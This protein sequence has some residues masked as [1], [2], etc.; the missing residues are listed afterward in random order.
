MTSRG[1][2]SPGNY[3][4][5]SSVLLHFFW[6]TGG[7]GD[8]RAAREFILE[9]EK[10]NAVGILSNWSIMEII[11]VVRQ[12]M[13]NNDVDNY[14]VIEQEVVNLLD[15][16]FEI[17]GIRIIVG[18]P[19]ELSEFQKE[20]P[21]LWNILEDALEHLEETNYGIDW[22]ETETKFKLRGIASAD[23][24]HVFIATS[25]GCDYLAT[26]DKGF[27]ADERPITIYDVREKKERKS[28]GDA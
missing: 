19:F 11:S 1:D 2:L 14:S 8:T 7:G 28:N 16:L 23:A 4:L 22:L 20:A 5:D 13:I 18:T 9:I 10:G 24:L 15:K 17:K 3:Y 12:S 6:R 26:F 25:F 27:W 21:L